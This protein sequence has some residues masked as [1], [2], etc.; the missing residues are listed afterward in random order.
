MKPILKILSKPRARIYLYVSIGILA[1]GIDYAWRYWSPDLTHE[2]RHYVIYSTATAEQTA[3]IGLVAEMVYQS[4][5]HLIAPVF[6]AKASH[7]KLKMKLYKDRKEFR[8]SNRGVGWP[9]GS[10]KESPNTS[11]PAA[12]STTGSLSARSTPTPTRPGGSPLW[13]RRKAWTKTKKI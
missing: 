8:H 5:L 4:Y 13:P 11:A 1:V 2:T 9:N 12:S 3:E 6:K 10:T 7:P